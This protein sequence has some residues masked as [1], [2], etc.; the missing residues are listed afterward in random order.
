M[1]GMNCFS[2]SWESIEVPPLCYQ[3]D[4]QSHDVWKRTLAT[5][6][7]TVISSSPLHLPNPN[8]YMNMSLKQNRLELSHGTIGQ[9]QLRKQ[10]DDHEEPSPLQ[11]ETWYYLRVDDERREINPNCSQNLSGLSELIL[12]VSIFF[13][14]SRPRMHLIWEKF[15]FRHASINLAITQ[16]FSEI[17]S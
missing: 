11:A 6:S 16:K 8:P 17:S 12:L 1:N 10:E 14:H 15:R 3:L 9:L 7:A 4:G 5:W 2:S 13:M